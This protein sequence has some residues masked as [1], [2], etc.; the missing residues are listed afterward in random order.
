AVT[1]SGLTAAQFIQNPRVRIDF[2][3]NLSLFIANKLEIINGD[4]T[5]QQKGM[6]LNELK[7]ERDYLIKQEGLIRQKKAK[8]YA[9]VD[10]HK[11]Q[12]TMFYFVKEVGFVGGI[13]E[14]GV[15]IDIIGTGIALSSTGLGA[16][17]G[18]PVIFCGLVI[19]FHGFNAMQENAGAFIN[20]DPKH[21]GFLSKTYE[22]GAEM[23]GYPRHYG[24]LIYGGIDLVT[25][26]RGLFYF[27]TKPD[28]WRLFKYLNADLVMGFRAMSIPALTL[29]LSVDG[30]TI[31]SIHNNFPSNPAIEK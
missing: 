18:I 20:S 9:V 3:N 26:A 29:E 31:Q 24:D 19:T 25:S 27:V 15:G 22:G 1:E 30:L 12:N 23:L 11:K 16:I 13:A 7:Q 10:V 4:Y 2:K 8:Q 21:K 17:I 28:S 5:S 6:A 14:V